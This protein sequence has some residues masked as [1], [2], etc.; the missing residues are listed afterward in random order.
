MVDRALDESQ[1]GGLPTRVWRYATGGEVDVAIA[2]QITYSNK[3][4]D[5]F[6]AKVAAEGQPRAGQRL[7][8]A[9]APTSLSRGPG[10]RRASPSTR[11]SCAR[12]SSRAVAEPAPAHAS[13]SRSR[14]SSPR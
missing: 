8:R 10:P 9:D 1:E 13:G 5:E 2:P 3:A 11:T 6:I 7:D 14:R 12:G 4:L